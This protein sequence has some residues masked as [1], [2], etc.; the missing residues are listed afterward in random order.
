LIVLLIFISGGSLL[1]FCADPSPSND[2][3][4]IAVIEGASPRGTG[5]ITI[6][7]DKMAVISSQEVLNT[8]DDLKLKDINGETLSYDSIF[9]PKDKRGIVVFEL[10]SDEQKRTFI[11]LEDNVSENCGLDS[12]IIVYG[13]KKNIRAVTRAKGR[14]L[15]IGPELLD[16]SVKTSGLLPGGPVISKSSGK[17]VAVFSKA[18]TQ[19]GKMS[20]LGVRIDTLEDLVKFD[21]EKLTKELKAIEKIKD[22][23]QILESKKAACLA[24]IAEFK[25][26]VDN[27]KKVSGGEVNV[28]KASMERTSKIF[29][30][31][32]RGVVPEDG[33]SFAFV[34]DKYKVELKKAGQVLNSYKELDSELDEVYRKSN[35][36][37]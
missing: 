22:F 23:I 14:I 31:K 18:R 28:L 26:K 11:P 35:Q 25:G 34:E 2:L 29:L 3:D 7:R 20:L 5:F 24:K 13:Y 17:V 32:V 30:K 10:V 6:F 21:K 27:F 16:L 1:C 12:S 9:I 19:D 37:K 33:W 36:I 15:A 4:K 8:K